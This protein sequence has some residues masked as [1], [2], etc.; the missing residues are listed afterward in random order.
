MFPARSADGV[1][2]ALAAFSVEWCGEHEG[3][4]RVIE[5]LVR[6]VDEGFS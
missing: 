6:K 5:L 2:W 1:R 4:A 3:K